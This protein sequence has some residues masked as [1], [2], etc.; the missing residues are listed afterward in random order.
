[1]I[2]GRRLGDR[3]WLRELDFVSFSNKDREEAKTMGES[4]SMWRNPWLTPT[5]GGGAYF[6]PL[7]ARYRVFEGSAAEAVRACLR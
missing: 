3:P 5:G 7:A 6:W 1:L 4:C 2:D